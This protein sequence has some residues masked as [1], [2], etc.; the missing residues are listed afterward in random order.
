M[1]CFDENII[2]HVN[3]DNFHC[4]MPWFLTSLIVLVKCLCDFSECR[5]LIGRFD[6]KAETFTEVFTLR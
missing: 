3:Y 6:R 4:K 2:L 1:E 5:S